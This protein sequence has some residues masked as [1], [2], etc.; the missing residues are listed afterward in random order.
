[1]EPSGWRSRQLLWTL[2]TVFGIAISMVVA[3]VA[4]RL[5]TTQTVVPEFSPRVVSADRAVQFD[6]TPSPSATTSPADDVDDDGD[7]ETDDDDD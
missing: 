7:D 2:L 4:L 5:A 6:A 1:M 3:G